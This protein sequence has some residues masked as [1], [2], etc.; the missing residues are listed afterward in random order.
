MLI[1]LLLPVCR[2][3]CCS[4]VKEW[5][6]VSVQ[7]SGDGGVQSMLD[8]QQRQLADKD[9]EI[10]QLRRRVQQLEEQA[11]RAAAAA[12][13]PVSPSSSAG[14]EGEGGGLMRLKVDAPTPQTTPA[15]SS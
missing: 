13:S 9:A 1:Q 12:Q 15:A 4:Y 14:E 6:G 2:P 3:V 11:E 10:A 7:V 5:L 8:G